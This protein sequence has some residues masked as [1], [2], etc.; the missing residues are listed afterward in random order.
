MKAGNIIATND[1]SLI[2]S[3][4][5]RTWSH[6]GIAID[7]ICILEAV[8]KGVIKTDIADIIK[9]PKKVLLLVRP[10]PLTEK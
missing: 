5:L 7:E 1:N 8:P 4:T 9:S 10:K 3:T 6:V 2:K